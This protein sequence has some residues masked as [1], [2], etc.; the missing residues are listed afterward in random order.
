MLLSRKI[1]YC[2]PEEGP[3]FLLPR[4]P[5]RSQVPGGQNEY[6]RQALANGWEFL[7]S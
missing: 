6:C 3:V 5:S 7:V 4:S 1:N 2:V